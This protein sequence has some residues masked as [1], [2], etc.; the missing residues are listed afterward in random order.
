MKL[1]FLFVLIAYIGSLFVTNAQSKKIFYNVKDFGAKGDGTTIDSGPINN[2]IDAA[3]NTGGGTIYFPPG[4]YASYTIRLKSNISLFIDQG[5][6]ILGAEETSVAGYDAPEPKTSY[7]EYQDF[8][9]NHWKNS[10]IWGEGLHDISI[11][12]QG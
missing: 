10:L 5:A 9:H 1:K 11:V 3:S 2:A 8:G 12:G 6:I 4:T 7:D